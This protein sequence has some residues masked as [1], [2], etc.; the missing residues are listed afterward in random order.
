MNANEKVNSWQ[1]VSKLATVI[2]L[3]K[4]EFPD[5]VA[6]LSPWLKNPETEKFDDPYSVDLAFHFSR[7]SYLCQSYCILMQIR[8]SS[9]TESAMQRI[10]KIEL[11]GH[12]YMGQQWQFATIENRNFQGVKLPLPEAEQKIKHICRQ[13]LSLWSNVDC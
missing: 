3:F 2:N 5:S 1:M 9:P 7:R 8:L 4:T 10:V 12:D 11:S 6:D 13:I